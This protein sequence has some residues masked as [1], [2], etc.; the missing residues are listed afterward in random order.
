MSYVLNLIKQWEINDLRGFD[1]FEDAHPEINDQRLYGFKE[2]SFSAGVKDNSLIREKVTAEIFRMAGIPAAQ[3]SF[4]KLYID[5]GDGLKYC[6]IY[7]MV[8]VV[9]DTMLKTQLGE[10]AGNLIKNSVNFC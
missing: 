7:A 1:E 3:T 8:E 10:D 4:Y 5:F 2:L 6:G 9:D